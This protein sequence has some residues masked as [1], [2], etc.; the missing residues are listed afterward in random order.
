DDADHDLFEDKQR[1][2][3]VAEVLK[4]DMTQD[5]A[6]SINFQVDASVVPHVATGILRSVISNSAS[7]LI[8]HGKAIRK[9]HG[10]I[11]EEVLAACPQG[12]D[13]VEVRGD[14]K[15]VRWSKKA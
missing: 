9:G 4:K 7:L 11:L 14:G 6:E 3:A 15:C 5:L 10:R 12:T 1:L 8:L 13:V 2:R